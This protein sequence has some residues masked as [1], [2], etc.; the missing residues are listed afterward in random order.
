MIKNIFLLLVLLII[1]LKS[2]SATN[3]TTCAD[4]VIA[5]IQI[6]NPLSDAARLK[7]YWEAICKG[8][9]NH[10]KTDANV[11]PGS[12][13]DAESRPITGVGTIL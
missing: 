4:L 6:L 3:P 11:F 2:F 12:F 10:L 9:L 1:S 13:Q 7:P 5:E 8:F